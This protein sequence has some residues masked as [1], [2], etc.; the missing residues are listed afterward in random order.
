MSEARDAERRRVLGGFTAR[1]LMAAG[2]S[3]SDVLK[4]GDLSDATIERV[5]KLLTAK[6]EERKRVMKWAKTLHVRP[7]SEEGKKGRRVG[8]ADRRSR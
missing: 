1:F 7:L 8:Q 2:Y 5:R 3:Q 4:F 6:V